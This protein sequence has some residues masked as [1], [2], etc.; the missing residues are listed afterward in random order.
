MKE[1]EPSEDG[2]T[3]FQRSFKVLIFVCWVLSL[4]SITPPGRSTV[5]TLTELDWISV[6][7]IVGRILSFCVLAIIVFKAWYSHQQQLVFRRLSPFFVFALWAL[8]S[9][10]WSP[11]R[12][13][14]FGRG[15]ELILLLMVAVVS[16]LSCNNTQRISRLFLHLSLAIFTIS[17]IS[18]ILFYTLPSL[19]AGGLSDRPVAIG[20]PNDVAASAGIGIVILVLST[21]LFRWRWAYVLMLP[22]LAVEGLFL[23]VAKSRV[24]LLAT[25]VGII[26]SFFFFRKRAFVA[27]VIMLFS[28]IAAGLISTGLWD[29]M[30]NSISAYML[31]GQDK[32]EVLNISGRVEVWEKGFG[33]FWESPLLG[34]GY[35][36]FS[37]TGV[38]EVGREERPFGAHNIILH[39][40][41]GTGIIGMFLFAL[42]LCFPLINSLR[43]LTY[44]FTGRNTSI[45]VLILFLF[46]SIEGL[47]ELSFLGPIRPLVLVFFT[48]LGIAIRK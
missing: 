17:F 9:T 42:A 10:I 41:T 1:Y 28:L 12:N 23:A 34:N 30:N 31:R 43:G 11:L 46:F 29:D 26:A 27:F 20:H 44:D 15:S 40:F 3:D 36:A 19:G 18:L 7:K 35:Y 48:V 21:S 45:M 5:V 16:G 14:T 33:F 32:K 2:N 38:V 37:P 4:T 39:V 25:A 8:I 24:A 22:A 6:A 47:F 13:V